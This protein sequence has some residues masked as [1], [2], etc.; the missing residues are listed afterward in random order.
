MY[1]ENIFVGI[2]FYFQAPGC[3]QFFHFP[4]AMSSGALMDLKSVSLV[5][6][7]HIDRSRDIGK[8][9]YI[10]FLFSCILFENF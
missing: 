9:V 1:V 4:C 2:K 5:C 3:Q 8:H 6:P 7:S 10:C